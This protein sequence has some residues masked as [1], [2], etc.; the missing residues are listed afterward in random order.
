MEAGA[1]RTWGLSRYHR[2][3]SFIYD[4]V[5]GGSAITIGGFSLGEEKGLN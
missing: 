1:K 3:P 2:R 4:K 5:Q